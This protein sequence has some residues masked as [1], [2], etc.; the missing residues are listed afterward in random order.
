MAPALTPPVGCSG[1]EASATAPLLVSLGARA[2]EAI[3][4]PSV[5][6]H[7]PPGQTA[8]QGL[9]ISVFWGWLAYCWA[10]GGAQ[11]TFR[12]VWLFSN[13]KLSGKF[14]WLTP[15]LSLFSPV[16]AQL[17]CREEQR[18]LP[19]N[20][21]PQDAEREHRQEGVGAAEMPGLNASRQGGR[22]GLGP[23]GSGM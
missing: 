1:L 16:P 4:D 18:K 17:L 3:K 22:G 6:T 20:L 23:L 21:W 2:D 11:P 15:T 12:D 10:L 7:L 9:L 14:P 5:S 13:V 19:L 8:P